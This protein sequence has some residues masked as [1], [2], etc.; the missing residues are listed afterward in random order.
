[1][2]VSNWEM[3]AG[4]PADF[5]FKLSFLRNPHGE[6]DRATPEE[7]NSWGSF[8]L[9]VAGENLCAH[10]EQGEVIE[11]AHWYMI[12]FLEWLTQNW[13]PIFHEEQLPLKNVGYSAAEAM[14][15]TKSPPI[16]LKEL[17]EFE[18]LDEWT[19][20]WDR[21]SVRAARE[22]GL[23]PDV[24]MRRYGSS[25]EVSTGAER[26]IGIPEEFTFLA[27]HRRYEVDLAKA[28]EVVYAVLQAASQELRRRLPDSRR[29]AALIANIE[30]IYSDSNAS[31]R[32]AWLAGLGTDTEKYND[33]SSAVDQALAGVSDGVRREIT[34]ANRVTALVV[35]G[36]AYA[37]LVYG[38][39]SP[40]INRDDVITL[41]G[42]LV[43][44]HVSDAS[45][46][47]N[48]L[49]L[50]FDPV[51]VRELTPG[52]QGSW[53]GERA[54][55]MLNAHQDR[56]WVDI[57]SAFAALNIPHEKITLSDREI[58]AVS[59]FGPNQRPKVFCN[60]QTKWGQSREVERFTLAH[61]L[62]HLLLDRNRASELAVASGPWAPLFVE[63]RANA[64]AAAFL[65]PTWL[66]RDHLAQ[67]NGDIR[68]LETISSLAM[69]L[70][71]SI[72]SMIDRLHNLG[73]LDVDDRF[74]LKARWRRNSGLGA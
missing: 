7:A 23:F 49:A 6:Q 12:S 44:N 43:K 47:L 13:D 3:Q 36:S 67:I 24:Y 63:Q 72:S 40:S 64:F 33:I 59:V 19:T 8:A 41:A 25:L 74:Q 5:A 50:S 18:W 38:A 9:W 27:P 31:N 32:M 57:H 65:M 45:P 28:A 54:C 61:E 58:R 11:A 48:K 60:T 2:T 22:G 30:A 62:A 55:E 52:E 68:D 53:L 21:H 56:S 20:W 34:G 15:L 39:Y 66:L 4:D 10:L 42:A 14:A 29:V 70:H 46:W 69:R 26:L 51:E 73:E 1:M 17:D 37:Q 71:V 35:Q 16:S